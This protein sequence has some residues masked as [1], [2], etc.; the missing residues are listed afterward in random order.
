ML[1]REKR[2]LRLALV[3]GPVIFL[4][5]LCVR[6]A[7]LALADTLLGISYHLQV[8][9]AWARHSVYSLSSSSRSHHGSVSGGGGVITSGSLLSRPS[10]SGSRSKFI[11]AYGEITGF[12]PPND[13]RPAGKHPLHTELFSVSTRDRKYFPIRFHGGSS[14]TTIVYPNIIPHPRTDN[15]WIVV[16]Q[17]RS[18]DL[19][20][21]VLAPSVEWACDALFLDNVLTCQIGADGREGSDVPVPDPVQPLPIQPTVGDKNKCIQGHMPYLNL[22]TGP[23]SAKVFY[24]PRS[25]YAIYGSNSRFTCLGQWVQDLRGL[26]HDWVEDSVVPVGLLGLGNSWKDDMSSSSTFTSP[27]GTELQRPSPYGIVETNWFLFWDNTGTLH[28]HHDITPRRSFARLHGDGSVGRDLAPRVADRDRTCLSRYLPTIANPVFESLQQATNSLA[29]TLCRR[30]DPT[31]T[32]NDENTFL[33]TILQHKTYFDGH[34]TYHPYVM[35]FRQR[36]PFE[37]WAVSLRPIW[38]SGRRTML[39][40]DTEMFSIHSMSWR[41]RGQRYHGYVDDV[42]LLAFT[43]EDQRAAGIDVLAGDLLANLGLC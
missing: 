2:R 19:A 27:N 30:T 4:L 41:E 3:F 24:G 40:G 42:L 32:P 6:L 8:G 11:G 25:P 35:V 39:S 16:A 17:R 23:H 12:A 15:V 22:N 28:V 34:A 43:I 1:I 14:E 26:V 18:E 29:V 5:L 21:G 9:T 31:C 20:G 36:A 37:V 38:I 7:S 13:V 10:G 33:F